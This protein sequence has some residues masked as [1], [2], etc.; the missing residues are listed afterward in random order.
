VKKY[1]LLVEDEKGLLSLEKRV[2]LEIRE[3]II[4]KEMI[5]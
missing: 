1:L 3:T 2:S 5:K 4:V